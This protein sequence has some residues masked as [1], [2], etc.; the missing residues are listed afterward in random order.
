[1]QSV[2]ITTKKKKSQTYLLV[3]NKAFAWNEPFLIQNQ[4]YLIPQA[5]YLLHTHSSPKLQKI[6]KQTAHHSKYTPINK[7]KHI[8]YKD[9]LC[10]DSLYSYICV[11]ETFP[12]E[13]TACEMLANTCFINDNFN[14][15]ITETHIGCKLELDKFW[16]QKTTSNKSK[17]LIH[18]YYKRIAYANYHYTNICKYGKNTDMG[19]CLILFGIPQKTIS[20]QYKHIWYYDT[21]TSKQSKKIEFTQSKNLCS[22]FVVNKTNTY[23][24][25]YK[26]AI[27]AWNNGTIYYP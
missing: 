1:T 12:K 10:T 9:S 5:N 19:T 8:F 13:N 6:N 7:G 18:E 25:F 14:D 20:T 23:T 4:Q 27:H 22:P 3:N 2:A 16:L 26:H 15:S 17:K 21:D 11:S 24:T